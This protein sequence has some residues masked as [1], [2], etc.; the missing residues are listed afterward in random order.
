MD[1]DRDRCRSR[2]VL[3]TNASTTF[4]EHGN[5]TPDEQL[6]L[7]CNRRFEEGPPFGEENE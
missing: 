7:N 6:V 3:P 4:Y 2:R 5:R 1:L